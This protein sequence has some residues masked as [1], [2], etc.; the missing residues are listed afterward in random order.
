[1][2]QNKTQKKGRGNKKE[3]ERGPEHIVRGE[4]GPCTE[5]CLARFVLRTDRKRI[6]GQERLSTWK[7]LHTM[8]VWFDLS[9]RHCWH[10]C[11]DE[12]CQKLYLG[13]KSIQKIKNKKWNNTNLS[14][15][16]VLIKFV[17][18]TKEVYNTWR[19]LS[20]SI[21][22]HIIWLY[23]ILSKALDGVWLIAF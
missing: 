5:V 6:R 17:A 11:V 3:R 13:T 8:A 1:M 16:M 14:T 21:A 20:I 18:H 22:I 19:K 23:G 12:E 9:E 15:V 4:K 2:H 7:S 10:G